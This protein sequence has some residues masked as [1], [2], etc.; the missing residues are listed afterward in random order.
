MGKA[1]E[2]IT[3]RILNK[4]FRKYD[5]DLG[6]Q[7]KSDIQ[8]DNFIKATIRMGSAADIMTGKEFRVPLE[9]IAFKQVLILFELI[10]F[11]EINHLGFSH[12][13]QMK[14]LIIKKLADND[15]IRQND[16]IFVTLKL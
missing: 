11:T 4:G 1:I 9:H 16:D 14:K 7:N 3:L 8:L 12:L 6:I 13:L 15:A 2:V 10:L 5:S